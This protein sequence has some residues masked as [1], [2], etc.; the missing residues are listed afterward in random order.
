MRMAAGFAFFALLMQMAACAPRTA[1]APFPS[2]N[3]PPQNAAPAPSPPP[4][5]SAPPSPATSGVAPAG[6]PPGPGAAILTKSCIVCHGLDQVTSQHK[7]ASQWHDTVNEMIGMGADV[8]D[9]DSQVLVEY[10][11]KNFGA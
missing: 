9:A 2:S 3:P 5:P 11:T 4:G 8:S 1:P 10:L 6:L 7:S